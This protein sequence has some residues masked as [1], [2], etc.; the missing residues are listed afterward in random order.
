MDY[1]SRCCYLL[2]QGLFVAD[3]AYY[4]G[5]QAPNFWPLFANVPEKPL[6]NGLGQGY[7]YDVVN[8]DVILNRMLFK[9][10]RIVLPDGMSYS[11][12]VL[13]D[14]EDMQLEVLQKLEELV[15]AGATIIGPKP[16]DVPGMRDNESRRK[17]LLALADKMWGPINGT[18][19]NQNSYGKGKVV[20]GYTA[21][22]W[23]HK[24]GIT[25]DFYCQTK[26]HEADLDYI[27]R[28]I[29]NSDIYFIRNKSMQPVSTDCFFRV[30]ESKPQFWDPTDGSIKPEFNYTAEDEGTMV[31]LN[32]A[33]GGSVFVIFGV[34]NGNE[35]AA[36]QCWQNGEYELVNKKGRTKKVKINDIPDPIQISGEWMVTFDTIWGAPA[37]VNLPKL[38]SWTEHDDEGVK[39]YSGAGFYTKSIEIPA[40]WLTPEQEV[41]I[42]LGDVR[43][44]AEV[45]INGK[46]AG[47][48][49]KP[50]FRID[51][52]SLVNS[53]TNELK[54]EVMNMW[55]NRLAGDQ[56]LPKDKKFTNT[57]VLS[58]GYMSR[59]SDY[60]IQP[61]GL[62]GP[63]RLLQSAKVYLDMRYK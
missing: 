28:Q 49:W 59:P 12:L 23:L 21:R 25:Q 50:P 7:D 10:G 31:Q 1:L 54:I 11:V 47:V 53:G 29:E 62:L 57:N 48:I 39:Y 41:Y 26:E 46:T 33:P 15:S 16:S 58:H 27:H 45:F 22:E 20:W 14:Q 4:Y 55:I 35:S 51:I 5:D 34:E 18:T 40:E 24:E 61:A 36:F 56:D 32:L 2:Q 9:D 52:T 63:V 3:V 6:L 17:E 44:L 42:D 19:I 38:I 37:E 60:Q 8:S 13:P 30:E 43:D